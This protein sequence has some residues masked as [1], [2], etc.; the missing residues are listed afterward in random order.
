MWLRDALPED[1]PQSRIFIYGYDAESVNSKSFENITD[2]GIQFQQ[3]I[4]EIRPSRQV[5]YYA[6]L[7]GFSNSLQGSVRP[8]VL[9]GHSLGGLVV[10]QVRCQCLCF[11]VLM[12][13]EIILEGYH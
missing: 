7:I 13:I 6:Y 8:L 11:M 3:S 2:L 12:L 10:K 1:L 9:I 4:K 5:R